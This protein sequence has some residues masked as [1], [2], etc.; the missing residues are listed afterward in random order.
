MPMQLESTIQPHPHYL[1]GYLLHRITTLIIVTANLSLGLCH[2]YAGNLADTE[3]S[4]NIVLILADDLGYGDLGCYGA[5]QI[6]TPHCDRLARE[7]RRFTD[8]HTPSAV[9]SPTRFGL[10]SGCYPWRENRVPRHL[11]ASE[12]YVFRDGES[13]IASLLKGAGYATGCVGKWHLGAQRR[14]PIEWNAPLT[15]GPRTAGFDYYFGVINSHNQTPFVLV[16]NETILGLTPQNPIAVE[17]NRIQK[18]GSRSRDEH[19]LETVQ[20]A[21]AV[22]FIEEHRDRPFFLYYPTAAVH[23]PYTPATQRQGKSPVG[24]YGDYVQEFDWAVGEVLA[25]LDRLQLAERTIVVV[26]SDNGG[27]QG[28][29]SAVGHKVNGDLRAH[30]GTAWEGG[31]RVAFLVRWPGQVPAGTV[32]DETICHVDMMATLCAALDIALPAAA[33][34]DSWNVLPAWL[35]QPISQ[36]L[37][38]AT[39]CVSQDLAVMSIRQGPWKLLLGGERG[40]RSQYAIAGPEL[41]DLATDRAEQNNLFSRQPEKAKEL[42]ALLSRYREQKHS[43]PG[44]KAA[45]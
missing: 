21:K 27:Q 7:G 38:E 16:E 39:V 23:D 19:A 6:R 31:H 33:G 25:T 14:S 2:V 13:T 3:C 1:L 15:P 11:M 22:S 40:S 42:T 10:L 34:P 30:K 26:T 32:C 8:A 28:R 5:T 18:S 44:W 35:G 12:A 9:C 37:R 45:P 36:P 20:A 24:V 4:P 43:R 41:Y 17:G 29:G